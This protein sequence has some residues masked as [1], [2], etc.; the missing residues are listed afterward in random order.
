MEYISSEVLDAVTKCLLK[1]KI[2]VTAD[3]LEVLR[4]VVDEILYEYKEDEWK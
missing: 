3:D 1:H 4:I 2:D